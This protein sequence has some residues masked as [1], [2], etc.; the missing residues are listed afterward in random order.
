LLLALPQM[1]GVGY[2]VLQAAVGGHYVIAFLVLLLVGKLAATSLTIAIGGSGG[3]FAPSLFMGA[4][5]GAAF[6]QTAHAILPSW[7]STPG[8][9]GLVGMGAVFAA[10]ARAPI[11]AVII[12]FE[13][14]GD[15]GIILPLMLAVVVATGL[16]GLATGDTIYTLKLRRRGVDLNSARPSGPMQTVTVASAMRE[17]PARVRS[18][19][20]LEQLI[21]RLSG[22]PEG[23]VLVVDGEDALVGL[24]S[25]DDL[26]PALTDESRAV[27][28]AELARPLMSLHD[29]DSLEDAARALGE[30]GEAGLPVIASHART[31]V[32][33]I[34]HRDILRAYLGATHPRSTRPSGAQRMPS[35]N[36]DRELV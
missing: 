1:Y 33:W 7:A 17:L 22:S 16:S 12:I 25:I 30:S 28:A 19:L 10:A 20:P 24:V 2:P 36:G 6:G 9:Y 23:A 35:R 11:T 26:Q 15:Y 32:G 8:A 18:T 27:T 3:V 13:L 4:V 21:E 34:S 31:A 5:L 29:D 14:T